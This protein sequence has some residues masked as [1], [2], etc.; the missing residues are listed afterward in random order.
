MI[1]SRG[2]AL[3]CFDNSNFHRSTF[4]HFFHLVQSELKLSKCSC[5][6]FYY[7]FIISQVHEGRD[8]LGRGNSPNSLQTGNGGAP[9]A[10]CVVGLSDNWNWNNPILVNGQ[11]RNM[12]INIMG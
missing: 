1:I 6:N 4:S 10:C 3:R 9:I 7:C 8:D 5:F 2:V 11:F 12:G